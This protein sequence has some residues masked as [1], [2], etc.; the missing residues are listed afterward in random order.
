MGGHYSGIQPVK[1]LAKC[2]QL[3]IRFIRSEQRH[4]N[5]LRRIVALAN[6]TA[7]NPKKESDRLPRLGS[8]VDFSVGE[9]RN[10]RIGSGRRVLA[11]PIRKLVGI[12]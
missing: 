8:G 10:L 11:I 7:Q 1:A 6:S 5:L 2:S 4:T 12:V 3:E 9:I